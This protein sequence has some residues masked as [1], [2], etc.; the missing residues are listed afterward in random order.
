MDYAL[1]A[2]EFDREIMVADEQSKLAEQVL[3]SM[4][5]FLSESNSD[6]AFWRRE[7]GYA[8]TYSNPAHALPIASLAEKS[9]DGI[10]ELDSPLSDS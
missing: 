1:Q 7:A 10:R 6:T 9:R 4:W 3:E 8:V 2:V 5:R